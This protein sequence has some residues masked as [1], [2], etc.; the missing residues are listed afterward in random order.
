M[1][2]MV[3]CHPGSQQSIVTAVLSHSIGMMDGRLCFPV[4]LTT[5]RLS[6]LRFNRFECYAKVRFKKKSTTVV[7]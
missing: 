3:V 7:L 4:D 5:Q 2:T 6:Y 1:K